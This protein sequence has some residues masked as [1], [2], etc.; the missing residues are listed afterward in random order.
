M[1]RRPI[2][3]IEAKAWAEDLCSRAEYASGEIRERLIRKGLSPAVADRITGELIEA[4]FIDDARFARAFVRDKTAFARWG[5]QKIIAALYQKRVGREEISEA[6]DEI[7]NDAY[8]DG[9][10]DLLRAKLR[11]LGS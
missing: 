5:K 1:T 9:L 6:I 7:D 2:T 4:R 8:V 11:S 3:A 10:A